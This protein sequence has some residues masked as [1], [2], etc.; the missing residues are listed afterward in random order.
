MKYTRIIV[1]ALMAL[2][3]AGNAD[4]QV[5]VRRQSKS[6]SEE[7]GSKSDR[8][9][10]NQRDRS[11]SPR[12][13][14]SKGSTD[15]PR[16]V[17]NSS[18]Q[19]SAEAPKSNP[20]AIQKSTSAQKSTPAKSTAAKKGKEDKAP[21][22]ADG[23]SLRQRTFDD[24]QKELVEDTPWQHV[25]YREIDLN[26]EQNA[27]LYYPIEPQDGLTNLFRVMLNAFTSGEL[28]AYE[29]LGDRESF[30][31]RYLA[32]PQDILDKFEIPYRI[33]QPKG[34]NAAESYVVDEIDV[35][36]AEVLSYYVKERWEFDQKHSR[37]VPR[38]L[39][40][41]PVLHRAG[42]AGDGK[43]KYPLFWVN[44]EDLR[45]FL[46]SH[47]VVSTGMNHAARYNMEEFFKLNMYKGTI[48]K[49][50]NLR[51]LTLQ[52]QY[53][54]NA[55]TLQMRQKEIDEKLKNFGKQIWV[56]DQPAQVEEKTTKTKSKK[57]SVAKEEKS[58]KTGEER[59]VKTGRVDRRSKTE[60]VVDSAA[61]EA[62]ATKRR[63]AR[64][65]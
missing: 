40:I 54:T 33:E 57:S 17:E 13:K 44:F 32:K 5:S 38:I 10:R 63:S 49:E 43:T 48:Y 35:P 29:Y 21:A 1:M 56:E 42:E 59:L 64:R 26:E 51:G 39:C 24:Y 60:V 18:A 16:A 36:S 55:D 8:S 22:F 2:L 7:S 28:K 27:S 50:Q 53:G 3:L 65:K 4:A 12:S 23:K 9:V 31:E 37:F 6:K 45:P 52:Q 41:C 20:G 62:N 25:V 47:L 11:N 58:E 46:R 34:R 19:E 14:E 15:G 61:I 30:A